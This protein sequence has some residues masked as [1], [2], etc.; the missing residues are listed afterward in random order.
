M[1]KRAGVFY[2][3]EYSS[4]CPKKPKLINAVNLGSIPEFKFD[5]D[6][7][8]YWICLED[9]FNSKCIDDDLQKISILIATLEQEAYKMMRHL[10]EPASPKQKTFDQLCGIME[11]HCLEIF[12]LKKRREFHSLQQLSSETVTQ[13]F[14]RVKEAAAECDFSKQLDDTIK[15]RFVTGMEEGEILNHI[16]KAGYKIPLQTIVEIASKREDELR[17][18]EKMP[19]EILIYI[20]NYLP[21][22][23]RVRVERVKK[24]WQESAKK[25]WNNIKEFKMESLY[26]ELK[27]IPTRLN[28]LAIESIVLRCGRYL[29]KIDVNSNNILSCSLSIIAENCPNI[30]SINCSMVSF[31]GLKKLSD[32]CRNITELIIKEFEEGDEL[33]QVLG[34]L[35]SKNQKL[36]SLDMLG[37]QGN[38]DCL[39]KLPFDEIITIKLPSLRSW[40]GGEQKIINVIEKSKNLSTFKYETGDLNIFT[41]LTNNCRNLT[42]LDLKLGSRNID[43]VD[44][45]LSEIFKSNKKIEIYKIRRFSRYYW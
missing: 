27:S 1:S 37:Y 36:Q 33:D 45:R 38:G 7:Y 17:V 35:F 39:S 34:D 32:N 11:K 3:E 14:T 40:E 28:S 19:E 21:I 18:I 20:F 13:W 4:R 9:Y 16:L 43:D 24:S 30:Q 10:C 44:S 42:E 12:V 31:N 15:D 41:A 8:V 23:D 6:W 2:T 29:K 26:A 5:H 22:A 25:S